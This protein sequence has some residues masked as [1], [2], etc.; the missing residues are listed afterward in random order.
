MGDV[1]LKRRRILV[2]KA[3]AQITGAGLQEDTTKT[4]DAVSAHPDRRPC[5]NAEDRDDRP[6]RR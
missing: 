2:S 1:D 5:G 4:S 6:S 3:V